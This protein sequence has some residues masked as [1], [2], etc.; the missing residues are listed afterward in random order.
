LAIDGPLQPLE[1]WFQSS[2]DTTIMLIPFAYYIKGAKLPD[3]KVLI[4]DGILYSLMPLA[5]DSDL[6]LSYFDPSNKYRQD[7]IGGSGAEGLVAFSLVSKLRPLALNFWQ[8]FRLYREPFGLSENL[9]S[10][11][12]RIN[13]GLDN[14]VFLDQDKEAARGYTWRVGFFERQTDGFDVPSGQVIEIDKAWLEKV[15]DYQ[16][17]RLG[18]V[19]NVNMTFREY[20]FD[21]PKIYEEVRFINVSP[22]IL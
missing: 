2:L 14:W 6:P 4:N 10:L 11:T 1:G 9:F 12:N 22:L 13:L 15:L 7:S 20:S 19:A 17:V 18:Y 21:K 8:A 5:T 3:P 16:K